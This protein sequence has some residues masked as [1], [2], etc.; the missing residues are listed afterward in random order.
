MVRQVGQFNGSFALAR[1]FL[2]KLALGCVAAIVVL[3]AIP[4][5]LIKF[6][7]HQNR[8][9]HVPADLG[10]TKILYRNEENW[11]SAL[12]PLPGDNET[13][14]LMYDLPDAIAGKIGAEG[15]SFFNRPE[16]IDRRVG[17]Q[18]THS[19]WHETP[20][21]DGDGG[22]S[23]GKFRRKISRYLDQYGFGIAVERSV[24]A[25]VDDAISTPGNFYSHGRT[26]LVIVIPKLKRAIF[27]YAG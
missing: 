5:G 25:M 23:V 10:V 3:I 14:I 8:M 6:A 17:Y 11:G 15:V 4:Y 22:W 19:E 21:V 12:M 27:A 18:R 7:E 1:K 26:G 9:A 2:R 13:G 20:I 16:N 24:E